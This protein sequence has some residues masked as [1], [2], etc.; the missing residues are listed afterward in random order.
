MAVGMTV[1]KIG[2]GQ[3]SEEAGHNEINK[4]CTVSR[5]R[6]V[7]LCGQQFLCSLYNF[8]RGPG[9]E[10]NGRLC[11]TSCQCVAKFREFGSSTPSKLGLEKMTKEI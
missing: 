11:P 3:R 4:T 8:K 6:R 2:S 5:D 7:V 10:I 1:S 9:H